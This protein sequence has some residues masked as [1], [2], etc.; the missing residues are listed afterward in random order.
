M[1]APFFIRLATLTI[2]ALTLSRAAAL[3]RGDDFASFGTIASTSVAADGTFT[4]LNVPPGEY[5]LAAS[6]GRE[7][8]EPDVAIVPIAVDGT[9]VDNVALTGSA[10]GSVIGQVIV[11]AK[12]VT[13]FYH[14]CSYG[15]SKRA[16]SVHG[17]A[18]PSHRLHFISFSSFT[19]SVW[20]C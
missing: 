11:F 9:D 14:L 7:S 1:R 17:C 18:S 20:R 8:S 12:E 2:V 4:L 6:S 10:G 16:A 19:L 15:P 3:V 5:M 13:W